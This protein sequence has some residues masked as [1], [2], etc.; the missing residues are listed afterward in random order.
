M[1]DK[2]DQVWSLWLKNHSSNPENCWDTL[3][4]HLTKTWLEIAG[5][6]VLKINDIGQSAAEP[7]KNGEGSETMYWIPE[8][9]SAVGKDIVQTQT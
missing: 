1:V 2:G 6:N 9:D 8:T 4:D 3:R 7:H 5:V